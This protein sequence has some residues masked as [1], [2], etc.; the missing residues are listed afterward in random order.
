VLRKASRFRIRSA[1]AQFYPCRLKLSREAF[2]PVQLIG[3]WFGFTLAIP[4]A[5]TAEVFFS[6][7]FSQRQLGFTLAAISELAREVFL[8][9]SIHS[10][11]AQFYPR[12][13]L[14]IES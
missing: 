9:N 13:Y 14:R 7:Q 1:A 11:P 6:I 4:F 5:R 2:S 3:S 8:L 10:T 12:C